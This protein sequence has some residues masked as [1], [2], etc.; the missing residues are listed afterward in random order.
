MGDSMRTNVA[1]SRSSDP[2]RLP[3]TFGPAGLK[4]GLKS[5]QIGLGPVVFDALVAYFGSVKALAIY[6]DADPSL[7]RREL[8]AGDFSRLEARND[9]DHEQGPILRRIVAQATHQA[10]GPARNADDFA[11]QLIAQGLSIF[12]QLAQY[13]AFRKTAVGQ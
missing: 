9:A 8:R 11:E 3:E 10:H 7:A 4:V 6:L 2:V 12:H 1:E 5:D 13:V